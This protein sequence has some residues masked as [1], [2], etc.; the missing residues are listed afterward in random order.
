MITVVPNETKRQKAERKTRKRAESIALSNRKVTAKA[1]LV[2][3][4]ERGRYVGTHPE[5]MDAEQARI[6]VKWHN[7]MS[8]GKIA[9]TQEVTFRARLPRDVVG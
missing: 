4:F 2:H 8:D 7:R 1:H 6:F 9:E 3:F 5:A